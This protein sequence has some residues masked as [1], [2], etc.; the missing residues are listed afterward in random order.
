MPAD[1]PVSSPVTYTI[2]ATDGV[3]ELHVPPVRLAES[4]VVLP[5]AKVLLPVMVPA[6]GAASTVISLVV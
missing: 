2:F 1:D 4:V 5:T 6:A 3:P